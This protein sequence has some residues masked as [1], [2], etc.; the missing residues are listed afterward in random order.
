MPT[1]DIQATLLGLAPLNEGSDR[2]LPLATARMGS[3]VKWWNSSHSYINFV[4]RRQISSFVS[5][6]RLVVRS[7]FSSCRHY[8][9]KTV[10]RWDAGYYPRYFNLSLFTYPSV[11]SCNEL[12]FLM[13]WFLSPE[14]W[15]DETLHTWVVHPQFENQHQSQLL[16]WWIYMSDTGTFC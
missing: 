14:Q 6:V 9:L 1:I 13:V 3:V 15:K 11:S 4:L 5:H 7:I 2:L 8:H 10:D 16:I 12:P